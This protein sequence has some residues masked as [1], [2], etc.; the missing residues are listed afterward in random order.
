MACA[1][2]NGRRYPLHASDLAQPLAH[3]WCRWHSKS[4]GAHRVSVPPLPLCDTSNHPD[5]GPAPSWGVQPPGGDRDR[6]G[7]S[8]GEAAGGA[9]GVVGYVGLGEPVGVVQTMGGWDA[10]RNRVAGSVGLGPCR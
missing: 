2:F 1:P 4:E 6:E 3:Y 7:V 8:G 5:V 10:E 9:G